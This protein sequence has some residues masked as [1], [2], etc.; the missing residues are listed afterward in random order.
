MSKC[1]TDRVRETGGNE[2][3]WEEKTHDYIC[4]GSSPCRPPGKKKHVSFFFVVSSLMFPCALYTITTI[5]ICLLPPIPPGIGQRQRKLKT[6]LGLNARTY[7]RFRHTAHEM[8]IFGLTR[9]LLSLANGGKIIATNTIEKKTFVIT[10]KK[11]VWKKLK[12]NLP[13]NVFMNLLWP[14]LFRLSDLTFGLLSL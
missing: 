12:A 4:N 1:L 11:K 9:S 2:N 13:K 3:R 14:Y 6:R 10:E 5:T 7:A 8:D